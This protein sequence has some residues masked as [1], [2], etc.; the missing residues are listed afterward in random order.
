MLS[1]TPHDG[2]ARSFASL[3]NMLDPT[4]IADPNNYT[5][6]DFKDKGL[7]IR[8][9]KKDIQDQV[10]QEFKK[11]KI[12]V[13]EGMAQAS[14]PEEI[15]FETLSQMQF[16]TIDTKKRKGSDLF[17]TTLVKS[18]MSSPVACI[19]SIDERVKKLENAKEENTR[20]IAQLLELREQLEA[21]D[22]K[23]FSKYQKLLHLIT[24]E[25]K[26]KKRTD[27]RLVIFTERIKTLEFLE[28]H[29]TRDLKLKAGQLVTMTGSMS[30]VDINQI[31]EDFVLRQNENET[32]YDM[33]GRIVFT[34][35]KG[36]TGVGLPRKARKTDCPCKIIVDGFEEERII[37]WEDIADLPQGEIHRTITD[38]TIPGGPIERTIIYKAPFAKCDREE[39]YEV[40]WGEFER[41]KR[42]VN[43][44]IK[45]EN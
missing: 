22:P 11:R 6:D 31:V 44:E 26:W 9:F 19:S 8:R 28:A 33:N 16:R 35:S 43:L 20:D 30:D 34:V 17:K 32:Y 1:A 36:L 29:L 14:L 45:V 10:E 42:E 5:V 41:R 37:G 25:M 38:D 7:V 27:D 12:F 15:A 24:K 40:A 13:A 2:S 3:L 21:V 4:A 18:L 39:D 23:S